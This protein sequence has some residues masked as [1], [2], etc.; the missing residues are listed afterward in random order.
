MEPRLVGIAWVLVFSSCQH[1]LQPGLFQQSGH[2][3]PTEFQMSNRLF[4][5]DSWAGATLVFPAL[6]H[7]TD[8]QLGFALLVPYGESMDELWWEHKVSGEPNF[9]LCDRFLKQFVCE[10][11]EDGRF[12]LGKVN[13]PNNFTMF[14]SGS[15]WDGGR[16][17]EGQIISFAYEFTAQSSPASGYVI[18]PDDWAD[19]EDQFN[20]WLP[21]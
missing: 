10:A 16:L 4:Y 20:E 9:M 21:R 15:E 1:D 3:V 5:Y 2:F 12:I 13:G 19:L 11:E 14:G 17:M 6:L 7:R 8:D 18:A